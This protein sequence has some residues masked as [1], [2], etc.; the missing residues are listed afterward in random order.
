[1]DGG[2]SGDTVLK[3]LI[4]TDDDTLLKQPFSGAS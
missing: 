2:A 1:M 4:D 3:Q